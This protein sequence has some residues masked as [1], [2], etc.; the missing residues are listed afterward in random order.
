MVTPD[1]IRNAKG[2]EAGIKEKCAEIKRQKMLVRRLLNPVETAV[3]SVQC[4]MQPQ[5]IIKEVIKEVEKFVRIPVE[6]I[7]EVVRV[8]EKPIIS[9]KVVEITNVIEKPVIETKYVEVEKVI[10]KVVEKIVEVEKK[11]V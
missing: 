4:D 3:K 9:E 2:M 5:T 1:L 7:K 10:E 8:V 6:V 11:E